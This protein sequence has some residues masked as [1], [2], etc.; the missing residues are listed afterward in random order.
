[1]ETK[2]TT[3]PYTFFHDIGHAWL[4]VSKRKLLEVGLTAKDISDY[5]YQSET[6]YYLEEDLDAGVFIDKLIEIGEVK[7]YK[8]FS[9]RLRSTHTNGESRIRKLS[10]VIS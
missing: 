1:M 5:S 10:R 7:D 4:R 8:E 3:K 6:N 9:A 2:H